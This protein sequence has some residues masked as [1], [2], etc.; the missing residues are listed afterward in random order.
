MWLCAEPN[1]SFPISQRSTFFLHRP[2]A[3]SFPHFHFSSVFSFRLNLSTFCQHTPCASNCA[4][5]AVA[6]LTNLPQT[7]TSSTRVDFP[8][9]AIHAMPPKAQPAP[10]TFAPPSAH[11]ALAIALIRTKPPDVAA[12]GVTSLV[13]ELDT[14]LLTL[15]T[16]SYNFE[17]RSVLGQAHVS[18]TSIVIILIL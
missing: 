6:T 16:M 3:L 7:H 1:R 12:R 9:R 2:L 17:S 4:N 13:H 10:S 8:L 11:V 5:T 14:T 18:S 15:Q